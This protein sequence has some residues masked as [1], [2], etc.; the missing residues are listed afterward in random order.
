MGQGL[1]GESSQKANCMWAQSY[2]EGVKFFWGQNKMDKKDK[3]YLLWTQAQISLSLPG[4]FLRAVLYE[5]DKETFR[6]Q[7]QEPET[8]HSS[9]GSLAPGLSRT[10][11]K[12]VINLML[13]FIG[14]IVTINSDKS[15]HYTLNI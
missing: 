1:W 4:M 15:H 11:N 10:W 3:L 13:L 9:P 2:T 6:K 7:R 8:S 5:D 14:T 12:M